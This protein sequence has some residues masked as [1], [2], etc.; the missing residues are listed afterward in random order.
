MTHHKNRVVILVYNAL[1]SEF[2][3]KH[4]TDNQPFDHSIICPEVLTV[5]GH[6]LDLGI[7]P[8]MYQHISS[9]YNLLLELI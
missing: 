4:L 7:S 2:I 5:L 6:G 3:R 9:M 1:A 8:I